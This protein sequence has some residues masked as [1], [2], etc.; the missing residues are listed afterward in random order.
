MSLQ[1]PSYPDP[2]NPAV[3][4]TDAYAWA[5]SITVDFRAAAS[6]AGGGSMMIGVNRSAAAAAANA[7]PVGGIPIAF[8]QTLVPANP[9]ETPPVAAV[10]MPTFAEM[11]QDPEF[12]AAF[13][14][15]RAK[16]YGWIAPHP[17]F[18]GA[19]EVP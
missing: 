2:T 14:T 4:I 11:M 12:A 13:A 16:L 5:T 17:A 1:L 10:L 9:S 19:T 7:P 3:P 6:G 8:G 15:I 18:A